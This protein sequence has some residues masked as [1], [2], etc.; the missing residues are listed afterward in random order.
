MPP[1]RRRGFYAQFSNITAPH[2]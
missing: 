1:T 2:A